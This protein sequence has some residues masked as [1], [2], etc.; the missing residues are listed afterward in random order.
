[1]EQTITLHPE[2]DVSSAPPRKISFEEFLHLYDGLFAEWIDGEVIMGSPASNE[3]Q[4]DSRFLTM[5]LGFFVEARELGEIRTAPF[6]MRFNTAPLAREPD[7]MFVSRENLYRLKPT[8]LDGVADLVIEIVS[9]E[10]VG[11]DRGEKFVEY[12]SAGVREYWIIDP[13]RRQAEF[14]FL[15][16]EKRY[17]LIFSGREGRVQSRVV[18]G[19]YLSVEWLW[20]KPMPKVA[21]I[22]KEMGVL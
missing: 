18:E 8:Y 17:E 22:L 13:Q 20:Q 1:M 14:Y 10:S 3:H 16:Q 21:P 6:V 7:L 4:D 12:E 19:F 15:N 9:P 5:L 11:R 2:S